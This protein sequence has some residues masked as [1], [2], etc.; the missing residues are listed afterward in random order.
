M[1]KKIVTQ[2]LAENNDV[3]LPDA[4]ALWGL[5][6]DAMLLLRPAFRHAQT[7]L[8]F[9]VIVAGLAIGTDMYGMMRVLRALRLQ[10]RCYDSLIHN[11]HSNGI[12]FPSLAA[13]WG[14]VVMPRLFGDK[15]VRVGGRRV[16]VADGIK[17]PKRGRKMPGVKLV[18][19]E[20][21]NKAEYTMAHSFQAVS[22]LV[23]SGE[24]IV[25]VLLAMRIDEG[26]VW[27]NAL[28][29]TLLT[30]M[31]TLADL[32]ASGGEPYI[33]VADAY[34]ASGVTTKGL[35]KNGN[36][37][38]TRMRSNSV[39]HA[40]PVQEGP[41]KRGRPKTYGKKIKLASLFDNPASM[42]Q[43]ASPVYGEKDVLIRYAVHDLLW[44]PAGC[45]VRFVAV[46]HPSRGCCVFMSTDTTLEA[47]EI[48][49]LY[50][51]RFKLGV[52]RLTTPHSVGE[53]PTEAKDLRLVA[54][55]APWS[56]SETVK[57][58]DSMLG[59]EYMRHIRL[60]RTV[61][62]DVASLNVVPVAETVEC[63]RRQ[64]ELSETSLKRRLS[65]AGYQRRHGVKDDVETGEALDVRR[66]N[67]AEEA[68]TITA[69]GKCERRRQGGGSG[70]ST[71]DERAAK[72]ARREGP[73]PASDSIVEVRHG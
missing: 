16:L 6:W 18:H 57:P 31:L 61:N 26:V 41:R 54:R 32:V 17:K 46:M 56:E 4:T 72:R 42:L 14:K 34:Y 20:S 5:W 9:S 69:S 3:T 2:N 8:W 10:R 47:V 7:F 68:F 38:V 49:R 58:S 51:L 33:L 70:R 21:D 25:A 29:E 64:Q 24:G 36:H 48:I 67:L 28:K 19:Q 39:A 1:A 71:V 52:S 35:L 63:A 55:E 22:A 53:S 59:K 37:L 23:Y 45:I 12:D 30:K 50:G 27:C 15:Q 60:Q 66:R 65:P 73:G 11:A 44:E 62:A 43:V 13:L 40:L